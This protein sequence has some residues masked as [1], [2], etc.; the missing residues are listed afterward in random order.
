V[1]HWAHFTQG[2]ESVRAAFA[3]AGLADRLV[4]PPPGEPVTVG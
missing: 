4:L 2:P 3:A 1:E